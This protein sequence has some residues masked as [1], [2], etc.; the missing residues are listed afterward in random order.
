MDRGEDAQ[1]PVVR[2][3]HHAD[4]T[5]E[6]NGLPV[7]VRPGQDVREAAYLSAVALVSS[8]AGTG[9]GAPVPATRVEPDG[10]QY[11]L[12]LYPA[13]AQ[14]AADLSKTRTNPTRAA[15]T[16]RGLAALRLRWLVPVAGA[17]VLLTALTTV[18]LHTSEPEAAQSS[19]NARV[20][21]S[22]PGPSS[23][24][25]ARA[26]S[27]GM[28]GDARKA[29]AS[30]STAE[31]SAAHPSPLPSARPDTP[32][33]ATARQTAGHPAVG[34]M[35]LALFGGDRDDPEVSYILTLTADDTDPITLTYVYSGSKA[36]GGTRTE[37]LSGQTRYALAGTIPGQAFCGGSVTMRVSTRP[38]AANGTVSARTMQA[39]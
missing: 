11:P 12:M 1:H 13:R 18:L 25:D 34:D 22:A 33:S 3:V 19:V 15:R 17:C 29:P 8:L 16:L 9:D 36:P 14:F 21:A 20:A 30:A 10:T 39:C 31:K 37:V 2:I 24:G 27:A 5:A 32:A 23:T 7:T 4:G 28:A 26:V 35:A 38:Q 6:V